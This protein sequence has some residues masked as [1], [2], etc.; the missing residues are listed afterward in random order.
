MLKSIET[1]PFRISQT[2]ISEMVK[3]NT[4]NRWQSKYAIIAIEKSLSYQDN[5]RQETSLAIGQSLVAQANSK[6][7]NWRKRNDIRN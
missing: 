5:Q 1:P 6:N 7:N 2:G 4:K 3:I